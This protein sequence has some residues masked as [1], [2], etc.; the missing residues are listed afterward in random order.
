MT[1]PMTSSPKM[2]VDGV[3][4][5]CLYVA[6]LARSAKFYA[7]VLGFIP[8]ERDDRMIAMNVAG[9]QVLLLFKKG[10][11]A[12]LA[13]PH[14]GDGQFHVAFAIARH[15]L[16][17]WERRLEQYGVIIEER[18]CWPRGGESVYFRDPDRHLVELATPGVWSVY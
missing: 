12:K 2:Q 11:S 18:R 14:D 7:E 5:T 16:P 15:Q 3:I 4:E 10:G 6:D 17:D 1:A 8:M 13:A 9:R